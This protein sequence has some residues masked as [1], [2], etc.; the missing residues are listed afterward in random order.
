MWY[1]SRYEI[2]VLKYNKEK[3]KAEEISYQESSAILDKFEKIYPDY[4]VLDHH[5]DLED[6]LE[7]FSK[8]YPDYVFKVIW[9]GED[10]DEWALY[11]YNWKSYPAEIDTKISEFKLK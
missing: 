8:D 1:D 4:D 11:V 9:F 7:N 2:Y 6:E 10:W 5:Y 3:D